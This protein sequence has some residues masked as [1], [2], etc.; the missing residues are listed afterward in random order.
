MI[1]FVWGDW[2]EWEREPTYTRPREGIPGSGLVEGEGC[3]DCLWIDLHISCLSGVTVHQSSCGHHFSASWPACV[4]VFLNVTMFGGGGGGGG[5][6][7][8]VAI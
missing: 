8:K 1:T 5:P 7:L 4:V 3:L 6:P 2:L